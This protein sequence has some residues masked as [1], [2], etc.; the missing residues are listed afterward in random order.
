M[1]KNKGQMRPC[2]LMES[3]EQLAKRDMNAEMNTHADIR[4]MQRCILELADTV[5]GILA[6]Q[7][8]WKDEEPENPKQ[9]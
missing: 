7:L 5:N 2:F 1:S 8:N 9:K 6:H 3:I 4:L